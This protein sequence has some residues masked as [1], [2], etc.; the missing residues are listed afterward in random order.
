M[1]PQKL[2]LIAAH[3]ADGFSWVLACGHVRDRLPEPVKRE[4]WR[5]GTGYNERLCYACPVCGVVTEQETE[6]REKSAAAVSAKGE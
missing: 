2:R 4:F 1:T 5:V 6:F 3:N